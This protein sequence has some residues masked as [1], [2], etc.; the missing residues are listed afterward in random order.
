MQKACLLLSMVR[1]WW[2]EA[3]GCLG[4]CCNR[5]IA[6]SALD[7]EFCYLLNIFI[8]NEVALHVIYFI[9]QSLN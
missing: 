1:Y 8:D 3:V 2:G 4:A 7:D 5:N 6:I 9:S